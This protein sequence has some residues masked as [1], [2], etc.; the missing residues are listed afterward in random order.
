M[1][2]KIGIPK[3]VET[4]NLIELLKKQRPKELSINKEMLDKIF[5]T[6]FGVEKLTIEEVVDDT[7]EIIAMLEKERDS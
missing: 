1:K 2:Q 4:P 3:L 6:L 5:F 7:D